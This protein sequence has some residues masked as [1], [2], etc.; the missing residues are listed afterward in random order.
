MFI[1]SHTHIHDKNGIDSDIQIKNAKE[2]GVNLIINSFCNKEDK[3]L[4]LDYLEK[5]PSLYATVGYYPRYASKI[6]EKDILALEE[7]ILSHDRIIG[8]G[9]IGL[10]YYWYKDNKE[11]QKEL[12]KM[13]L[14][15]AEKLKVPVVIHCR[16][17]TADVYEILKAYK[18]KGVM[19]CFSGSLEMAKKYIDLGFLL[20]ISG[21]LTFSNSKLGEVIKN[22]PIENIVLET[23][24]PYLTPS[25]N[26]G[27]KNESKNIIHIAKK[28][29][30][31]KSLELSEVAKVTT[32]NIAKMFDLDF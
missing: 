29:A 2:V 5:Y 27:Q 12:F 31:L 11:A 10:D 32:L 4:V 13:Q 23:D 8:I 17:A 21:V 20:G 9:E 24:S 19:H 16:E 30:S 28:V 1:D 14:A 18:V 25:P 3:D 26:R 22:V 6:K 15:L 7:L